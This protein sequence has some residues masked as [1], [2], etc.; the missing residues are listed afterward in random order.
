[1]SKS[2]GSI[3]ERELLH[4]FFDSGFSGVRVAGSGASSIPSP[5]LV[6][7]RAGQVLAFEVKS[8]VSD[9]VYISKSQLNNL[10]SFSKVFGAR[11]L[12]AVKFINRGWRFFEVPETSSKN[13]RFSFSESS[14]FF[15][16]FLSKNLNE[17]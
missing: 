3:Y 6:I 2:K 7:G 9:Y 17:F 8:T 15:E 5:D 11:P 14:L 1:M 13:V 4:L 10:L 16:N 12:V